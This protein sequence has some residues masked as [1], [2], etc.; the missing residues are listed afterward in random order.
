MMW[1]F[2]GRMDTGLYL[3]IMEDELQK[4]LENFSK[5]PDDIIF[6]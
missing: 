6:Q 3:Q 5:T 2:D 4:T 1:D